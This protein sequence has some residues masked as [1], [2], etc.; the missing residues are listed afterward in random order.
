M[1]I[2]TTILLCIILALAGCAGTPLP[3]TGPAETTTVHEASTET[4]SQTRTQETTTVAPASQDTT[5]D[6]LTTR[7][8]T[9]TANPWGKDTLTVGVDADAGTDPDIRALTRDAVAYWNDHGDA[10]RHRFQGGEAEGLRRVLVVHVVEADRGREPHADALGGSAAVVFGA[11]GAARAVVYA[12][13]THLRH[14]GREYL[15]PLDATLETLG[16]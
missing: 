4:T 6:S 13:L 8:M 15:E 12:L 3:D 1:A 9:E 16:Y 11:G 7:P 14:F 5:A 2:R 10:A